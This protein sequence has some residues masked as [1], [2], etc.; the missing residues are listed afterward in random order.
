MKARYDPDKHHRRSVR[1]KGYDYSQVG[2]Y[3]VTV[4]AYCRECRFGEVSDGEMRLSGEGE[5]VENCWRDIPQHFPNAVLDQWV[6]MPNHLH[7]II[8][9]PGLHGLPLS[10]TLPS[11]GA[12]H[13]SPST[14]APGT[15]H[16]SATPP[17]P[18][19]SPAIHTGNGSLSAQRATHAWPVQ[20]R[21]AGPKPQSVGAI[22]GSFKSAVTRL[23]NGG[24][25]DAGPTWQRNFFEHV[26]RDDETLNTIRQYIANNPRCWDDDE[27]NPS[28]REAVPGQA[29]P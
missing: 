25:H 19:S 26:I 3:F 1:L 10:G 7:G 16:P 27:E 29:I 24:R 21:P 12:T 6:V 14:S 23:L 11:V 13:A 2:A 4:V 9:I 17:I 20:T 22:V 18:A 15:M 5:V 8:I 28:R